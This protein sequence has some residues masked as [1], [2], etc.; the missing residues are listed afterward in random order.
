MAAS[1]KVLYISYDGMTDPLGKS[2][3]LSYLKGLSKKSVDITLISCE[4]PE[5]F[6]KEKDQ[7]KKICEANNIDWHPLPYH[8]NPPVL[9]AIWDVRNIYR[10]AFQLNKQKHFNIVHCRGYISAI[11]GLSMKRKLGTKF[12]FDMRGFWADEKVDGGAWDLSKPHYKLIYKY[13]KDKEKE[14]F[15]QAD[16]CVSLTENGKK[17]IIEHYG[18]DEKKIGV[19]PTCVNYDQFFIKNEKENEAFKL[20]QRLSGYNKIFLYSGSLGTDSYDTE[21]VFN[22]FKHFNNIFKNSF[23][24]ILSKDPIQINKKEFDNYKVIN[25]P[26]AEVN[27]Y[28]NIADYAF[29]FYNQ[30]WSNIGRSPTKLGEYLGTGLNVISYGEMGDVSTFKQMNIY[31]IKAITESEIKDAVQHFEQNKISK[32]AIFEHSKDYYSLERGIEFYYSCYT[33][34][35]RNK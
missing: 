27:N 1:Q 18:V 9:S 24:L 4:K 13:F 19:I 23:L 32:T 34:L 6:E 3:V 29:V 28:L 11:V 5:R 14:F 15:L 30:G 26:F 12:L 25:A 16:H 22:A 10:K 20:E 33:N 31:E 2:Q 35:S 17:Y 8:K 21:I 7:I